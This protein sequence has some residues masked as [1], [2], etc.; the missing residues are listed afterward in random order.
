[1]IIDHRS[2][3]GIAEL[4]VKNQLSGDRNVWQEGRG[5]LLDMITKTLNNS[6]MT[7]SVILLEQL[8][9]LHDI[10][11]LIAV[12]ILI[13]RVSTLLAIQLAECKLIRFSSLDNWWGI[14]NCSI[15]IQE[16]VKVVSIC[17]LEASC[18]LRILKSPNLVVHR[19]GSF[20]KDNF[21]S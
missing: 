12:Y 4:W 14:L 9:F 16:C 6:R 2:N 10:Y 3:Y 15:F 17:T 7:A 19:T 20:G 5:G 18:I 1:M 8:L 13:D 11:I 21:A